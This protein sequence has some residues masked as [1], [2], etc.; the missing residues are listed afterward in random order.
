M[1]PTLSWLPPVAAAS[2][3]S[4]PLHLVAAAAM[5]LATGLPTI[6]NTIGSAT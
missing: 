1:K 5:L 4:A 6:L 3:L 2:A